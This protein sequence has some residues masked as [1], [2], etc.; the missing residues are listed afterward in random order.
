MTESQRITVRLSEIRQRL[1]D[2]LQIETRSA[3]EQT[4][5]ENLTGEVQRLEPELRAAIAAEPEPV[6]EPG[7][8]PETR[9]RLE[10]RGK[11]TFGAFLDAAMAGRLPAGPEAEYCAALGMIPEK[12]IPLDLFEADR[13][14]ET[15]QSDTVTPA[16]A[17][18]T[19]ATLAPIQ[20]FV[21]AASIAPRLG[22]SMPTVGSGAYSE[23]RISTALTAA[24][25][26]KGDD[27]HS[28]A[29]ALAPTTANARR[30][31]ARLS[32]A[33]EDVAM[34]GQSN[35]EAA[36]RENAQMA[37]SDAYDT[38]CIAGDGNAP[39]INGLINQLT[40]PANPT[41]VADFDAFVAAFVDQIDGLWASMVSDV[42]IVA[43]VDAYKLSAKTF[44]DRVIDTG[45]RGG[46]SLGD[47]SAASYLAR[48]TGGWW[49]NKRMPATASNIARGIVHRRGRSGMRT[50]VHP[51]WGQISIDDIYSDSASA[52]RH[53]SIHVLVGDRVLLVQPDAYALTEFKVS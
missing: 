13:P 48:E 9:E 12:G 21:F 14:V 36:L 44:R 38:Q 23:A 53:F 37:L 8:D 7:T 42:A 19:G 4:E 1:N 11:A 34:V 40:D 28:T 45:N 17:T 49:T 29:A 25:K 31:S 5:M 41:A 47:E 46:V 3:D 50:A 43:N 39:N 27:Q 2:L 32:I 16:P 10:L 15:R 22:I 33:A 18:G 51:T 30:I 52:T 20:P 35:F 24:A 26:N 6:T